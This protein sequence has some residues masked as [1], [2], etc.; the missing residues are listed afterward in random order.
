M[1]IFPLPVKAE[2]ADSYLVP[3]V[4][5]QLGDGY[6]QVRCHG[7]SRT[8]EFWDVTVVF[9]SPIAGNALQSFLI[10]HGQHEKFQWQSPLDEEVRDYQIVG[11]V[12][13]TKR[14]G[15]GD[16]PVFFTRSMK[17][18]GIPIPLVLPVLGSTT[19]FFPAAK[20]VNLVSTT[21]SF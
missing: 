18:R 19:Y 9:D 21:Y 17:F 11:A 7:L 3:S 16:K 20:S 6:E 5:L 10:E 15:G 1:A 4:I 2:M 8:Q 14:N 13:G 12:S